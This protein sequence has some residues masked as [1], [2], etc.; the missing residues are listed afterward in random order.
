[1]K[2][3]PEWRAPPAGAD[4]RA[5]GNAGVGANDAYIAAMAEIIDDAVL[6]DNVDDLA[7]LGVSVET[8]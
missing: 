7:A 6:T 5:S 2:R 3:S 8:Y 1:M 4:D